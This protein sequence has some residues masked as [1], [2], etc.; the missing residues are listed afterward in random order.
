VDQD[1]ITIALTNFEV[2]E[3]TILTVEGRLS[4]SQWL[5]RE[6]RRIERDPQRAAEIRERPGGSMALFVNPVK[7]CSCQICSR[8]QKR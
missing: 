6:K 1:G 5:Y 2:P 3:S 4:W 7:G 8:G